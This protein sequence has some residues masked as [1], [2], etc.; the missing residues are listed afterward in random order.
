MATSSSQSAVDSTPIAFAN[1]PLCS[2]RNPQRGPSPWNSRILFSWIV[3]LLASYGCAKRRVSSFATVRSTSEFGWRAMATGPDAINAARRNFRCAGSPSGD[4][5]NMKN[6]VNDGR[7][8]FNYPTPNGQEMNAY[9]GMLIS[10]ETPMHE[11]S[12]HELSAVATQLV[13]A[14]CKARDGDPEATR[15]H[16]AY[17]VALLRGK[18]SI[19]PRGT[20]V[21]S[22][23]ET[24]VARG[25]LPAWQ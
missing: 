20:R 5:R 4:W 11:A 19:G 12:T 9:T 2:Q 1:C 13:E 8:T 6:D 17:A 18:P 16:I 24:H 15:A 23:V 14:A 10:P 3:T 25:G 21:L 22:N 7:G